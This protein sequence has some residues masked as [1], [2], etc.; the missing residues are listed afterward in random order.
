MNKL[1]AY[2][3]MQNFLEK[4]YYQ[5]KSGDIGALLGDMILLDDEKPMDAAL[6]NDWLEA[7]ESVK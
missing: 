1:E 7:I 5:T 3:A 2:K 6:W 4:I